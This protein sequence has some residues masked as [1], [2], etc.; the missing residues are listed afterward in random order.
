VI[1]LS[2]NREEEKGKRRQEDGKMSLEKSA[3]Y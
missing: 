3:V 1:P 2:S